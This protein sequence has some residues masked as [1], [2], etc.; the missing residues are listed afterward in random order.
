MTFTRARLATRIAGGDK[1]ITE[2]ALR[3]LFS[4][5]AVGLIACRPNASPPSPKPAPLIASEVTGVTEIQLPPNPWTPLLTNQPVQP[6]SQLRTGTNSFLE[7]TSTSNWQRVLLA[8]HSEVTID[9]WTQSQSPGTPRDEVQINLRQGL[10]LI[11]LPAASM[12][13]GS[14]FE[15]KGSNFLA[16]VR[17]GG[18]AAIT[19]DGFVLVQ[20]GT[21][22]CILISPPA[23]PTAITLNSGQMLDP[24]ARIAKPIPASSNQVWN[25]LF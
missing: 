23:Q 8:N 21:V 3:T 6:G 19:A 16:G 22:V 17:S 2:K 20:T 25:L 15:V 10:L 18:T 4:L 11:D 1:V 7:L 24:V 14:F 13:G 12:T 9:R 5:F